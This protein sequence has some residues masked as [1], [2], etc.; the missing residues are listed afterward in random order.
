MSEF[1]PPTRPPTDAVANWL[2]LARFPFFGP[3]GPSLDKLQRG[4]EAFWA[5]QQ[6]LARYGARL[7]ITSAVALWR[8]AEDF[9][10][11]GNPL[12]SNPADAARRVLD[13]CEK[14]F[15][16]EF[17]TAEFRQTQAEAISAS[18]RFFAT[19]RAVADMLLK[20]GFLASRTDLDDLT[21]EVTELRRDVRRL[22]REMSSRPE[23]RSAPVPVGAPS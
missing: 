13:V 23:G 11:K 8:L 15:V 21:R 7:T 6:P 19:Q 17:E 3:L 16:T 20:V 9:T 1:A 22:N 12:P 10:T 18:L 4:I 14:A 2:E 5:L